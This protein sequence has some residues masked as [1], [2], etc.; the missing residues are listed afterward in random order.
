[1]LL[2]VAL[3]AVGPAPARAADTSC[4]S[5]AQQTLHLPGTA[6]AL[7]SGKPVTIVALGSSSTVGIGASRPAMAYPTRLEA[8]LRAA[9]PDRLV[10]VV[11]KGVGGETVLSTATRVA[12][13]VL[14]LHP[15]LVIWQVGANDVLQHVDLDRF[16]ATLEQAVGKLYAAGIDI[17]LMDNQVAP[18]LQKEPSAGDYGAVV[19]A[20]AARFRVSLFSRTGL[21]RDWA[22]TAN[23]ARMIGPDGLHH[24]DLGYGCLAAALARAIEAAVRQP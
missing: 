17:V 2:A 16:R 13:D 9:W 19:A 18:A 11:N 4:P 24:T 1:M 20:V 23:D 6:A 10:T 5:A 3:L 12:R 22:A 7:A 21:M 14:A 15:V 8:L